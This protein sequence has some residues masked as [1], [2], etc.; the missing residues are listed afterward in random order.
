MKVTWY[1]AVTMQV[2]DYLTK[3]EVRADLEKIGLT[4]THCGWERCPYEWESPKGRKAQC[5]LPKGHSGNTHRGRRV[6]DGS[7]S[8]AD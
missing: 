5:Q 8:V 4:V 3:D 1:A 7:Q 2:D 6:L